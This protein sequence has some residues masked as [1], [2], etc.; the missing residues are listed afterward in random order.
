MGGPAGRG[1]PPRGADAHP[2]KAAARPYRAA[3]EMREEEET[4]SVL[5][6][7][8]LP[9]PVRRAWEERPAAAA[10]LGRRRP[11]LPSC[12][13]KEKNEKEETRLS[14]QS[15]IA[16]HSIISSPISSPISVI[17]HQARIVGRRPPLIRPRSPIIRLSHRPSHRPSHRSSQLSVIKHPSSVIGLPPSVANRHSHLLLRMRPISHQSVIG[18]SVIG[19]PSSAANG[20]PHLL[21]RVRP[22]CHSAINQSSVS[23][24][25]VISHSASQ[26]P[27]LT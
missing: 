20:H 3:G 27:P 15:S 25:S 22:I 14:H 26:S 19:P 9:H 6:V 4:V 7:T 10:P 16:H 11:P 1:R 21:L 23:H 5:I 18:Q 12:C 24:H 13:G 8:G 2:P 17:G